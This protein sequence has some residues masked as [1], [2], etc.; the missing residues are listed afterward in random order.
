MPDTVSYERRDAIA[1]LLTEFCFRADNGLG[2]TVAELFSEEA[3][4]DT[5]HLNL[6]GKA[7][8]H[9]WFANHPTDRLTRHCWTNMRVTALGKDRYRVEY[10]VMT[11]VGQA[12]A[13]VQGGRFGI[14]S[15]ADEVDFAS[16][17]PLFV[18][19]ALKIVFQGML[20]A[21]ETSA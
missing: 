5:P 20:A 7:D 4:L 3:T 15:G 13:P 9:A 16:G 8:I 14:G 2:A 19:R 17:T 21:P 12:P 11:S 1:V 10:N 6:R 18:S